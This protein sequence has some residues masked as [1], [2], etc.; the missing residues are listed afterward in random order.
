MCCF[1]ILAFKYRFHN[2]SMMVDR[3]LWFRHRCIV[4]K[5]LFVSERD[6]VLHEATHDKPSF[7]CTSCSEVFKTDEQYNFHVSV[8]CEPNGKAQVCKVCG[9][10]FEQVRDLYDHHSAVHLDEYKFRCKVCSATFSWLENL[11]KHELLHQTNSSMCK[12]CGAIFGSM[13]SLKVHL[14]K[15]HSV[16]IRDQDGHMLEMPFACRSNCQDC[17]SIGTS[18]ELCFGCRKSGPESMAMRQ[19]DEKPYKCHLCN[20]AFKYDFSYSLHMKMHEEKRL[21]DK[22]THTK[23][24]VSRTRRSDMQALGLNKPDLQVNFPSRNDK[25]ETKKIFKKTVYIRKA[26]VVHTLPSSKPY[27]VHLDKRSDLKSSMSAQDRA[28]QEP[29]Q[30]RLPSNSDA[31]GNFV[32][33]VPV[34]KSEKSQNF[35]PNNS[36]AFTCKKCMVTFQY[37]FSYVAHMKY[38]ERVKQMNSDSGV[39]QVDIQSSK[40]TLPNSNLSSNPVFLDGSSSFI[41]SGGAVLIKMSSL[42]QQDLKL[43]NILE[44]K[45]P[46]VCPVSG[47]DSS[48][49]KYFLI[50]AAEDLPVPDAVVAPESNCVV[51]EVIDSQDP[52]V[53]G[54]EY[55]PGELKNCLADEYLKDSTDVAQ[56]ILVENQDSSEYLFNS[57]MQLTADQMEFGGIEEDGAVDSERIGG[58]DI[59]VVDNVETIEEA[60]YGVL[61]EERPEEEIV[62]ESDECSSPSDVCARP[63]VCS[64][65]RAEFRWKTGLKAHMRRHRK[66][67]SK[68][69]SKLQAVKGGMNISGHR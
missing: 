29:K 52:S 53:V 20:W 58:S 67:S 19:G 12:T 37:D 48:A 13:A 40:R 24:F 59:P 64:F 60:Y 54:V 33:K 26:N 28:I 21:L 4:C 34:T 25:F 46:L 23:V 68:G 32:N 66:P 56:V 7:A 47:A 11:E 49:V 31:C 3:R 17:K 41:N 57:D 8:G 14:W 62:L 63:H 30:S 6:L 36:G 10:V 61:I 38:H 42:V 22:K 35:S 44:G 18:S 43:Y 69:V 51:E 5:L 9:A 65:C 1:L 50:K 16:N 55:V 39:A 15:A 45:L 27:I 2:H